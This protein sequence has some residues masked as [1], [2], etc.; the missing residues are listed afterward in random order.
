MS[1]IGIVRTKRQRSRSSRVQSSSNVHLPTES[2]SVQ[3]SPAL[4]PSAITSWQAI[5]RCSLVSSSA[6]ELRLIISDLEALEET[7]R[8]RLREISTSLDDVVTLVKSNQTQAC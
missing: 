8:Q 4:Y 2:S 3:S 5:L 7:A 1:S 6:P